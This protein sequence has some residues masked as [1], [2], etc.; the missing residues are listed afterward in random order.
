LKGWDRLARRD[1]QY[2]DSVTIAIVGK[3]TGS[4]DAYLSVTRS[5]SHAAM[6]ADRHLIV[7]WVDST[8]LESNISAEQSQAE[9]AWNALKHC[10][11]ILIPGG[12]GDRGVMG[13][14]AACKYMLVNTKFHFSVSVLECRFDNLLLQMTSFNLLKLATTVTGCGD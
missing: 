3:Y 13:K 14:I 11:G 9:E 4:Q 5:L 10:D 12:F 7:K 8:M 6:A 1:D 2:S